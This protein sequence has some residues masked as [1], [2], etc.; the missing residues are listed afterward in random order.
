MLRTFLLLSIIISV[1]AKVLDIEKEGA[2]PGNKSLS[3]CINNTGIFNKTLWALKK[4][5]TLLVPKGK[6]FHQKASQG[7]PSTILVLRL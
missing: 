7:F 4:G 3:A 6:I 5:D 2:I 1:Y